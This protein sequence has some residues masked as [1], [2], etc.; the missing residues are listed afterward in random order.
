MLHL[1]IYI[2]WE[3]IK[4]NNSPIL[5]EQI[6]PTVANIKIN[7]KATATQCDNLTSR[8]SCRQQDGLSLFRTALVE[9][10]DDLCNVFFVAK[11]QQSAMW[12]TQ[13]IR[14]TAQSSDHYRHV[15][16]HCD[17][18]K[19]AKVVHRKWSKKSLQPVKYTAIFTTKALPANTW[20]MLIL[21]G[22]ILQI[23]R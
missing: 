16:N 12:T 23:T 14:T 10:S 22:K 21:T 19:V 20:Y 17:I 4:H 3:L 2:F 18:Y 5:T 11:L 1:F 8:Q 6:R 15:S 7:F 9:N 13:S